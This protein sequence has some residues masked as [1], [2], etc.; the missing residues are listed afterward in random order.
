VAQR[1]TPRPQRA[2]AENRNS[3]S[4][5][6]LP[7]WLLS[8]LK[9]ITG[10]DV[11]G[12]RSDLPFLQKLKETLPVVSRDATLYHIPSSWCANSMANDKGRVHDKNGTVFAVDARLGVIYAT[13]ST[14][15]SGHKITENNSKCIKV[16]N[17][18][19]KTNEDGTVQS[20]ESV[21][22]KCVH[23]VMAD[24]DSMSLLV[25]SGLVTFGFVSRHCL[26]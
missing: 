18:Y 8:A 1:P 13:C 25:K 19:S 2:G 26:T 9:E 12:A 21:K 5:S 24:E 20:V 14:G 23:W 6:H 4:S 3:S 7:E 17:M 11:T 15:S 22:G 16:V 10:R